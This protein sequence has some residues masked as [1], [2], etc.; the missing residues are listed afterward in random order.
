MFDMSLLD[1]FT[2]IYNNNGWC[3]PESRSGNGSELKNTIKLR[4]EL[5][6]LFVKYNI[7]SILDIP[8]GDFNWMKEVDLTNIEYKGADIVESLINLNNTI[9][10][11][12]D[13]GI[14][15]FA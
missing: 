7:K 15:N 2:E 12:L 13:L 8:C 10:Q 1:K 6:Y 9:E 11:K 14:F 4:S 5:P 3:S